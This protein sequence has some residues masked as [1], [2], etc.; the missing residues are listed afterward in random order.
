MTTALDKD[1]VLCPHCGA[2]QIDNDD[3]CRFC[4]K[5]MEPVE[6]VKNASTMLASG[7]RSLKA[8]IRPLRPEELEVDYEPA[9]LDLSDPADPVWDD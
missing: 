3:L 6:S 5:L 1:T 4:G 9:P 8:K 7:L 2:E